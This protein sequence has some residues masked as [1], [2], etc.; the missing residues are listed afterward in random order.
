MKVAV[1]IPDP[2][3]D[4]AELLAKKLGVSRSYIYAQALGEFINH[5]APDHIT[6]AMNDVL[7]TLGN[8]EDSFNPEAARRIFAQTDW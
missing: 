7:D 6:Q 4:D 3:F 1:S 2:I 5:H 8:A